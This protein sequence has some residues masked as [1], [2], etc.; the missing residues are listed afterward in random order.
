MY[1]H[2]CSLGPRRRQ[3]P[4]SSGLLFCLGVGDEACVYIGDLE[5]YRPAL[6]PPGFGDL[7]KPQQRVGASQGADVQFCWSE[8]VS[9]QVLSVCPQKGHERC[10]GGLQQCSVEGGQ[11]PQCGQKGA[12]GA[13]TEGHGG[14]QGR[15]CTYI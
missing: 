12:G 11:S 15:A 10:G 13:Q 14:Q 3:P 7:G 2:R 5:I 8:Y 9:A 1:P 6:H 4:D